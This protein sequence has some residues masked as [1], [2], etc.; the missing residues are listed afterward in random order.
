M[1]E[2]KIANY[3]MTGML[4]SIDGQPIG[5]NFEDCQW[6]YFAKFCKSGFK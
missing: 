5:L 4:P 2:N 1:M 6:F 3:D